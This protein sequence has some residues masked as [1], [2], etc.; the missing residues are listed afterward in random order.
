MNCVYNGLISY[1]SQPASASAS[2]IKGD[3][4]LQ[5][6]VDKLDYLVEQIALKFNLHYN[7]HPRKAF[8]L[9]TIL[10]Y[11]CPGCIVKALNQH[12]IR[13][14]D[15]FYTENHRLAVNML[16]DHLK[17]RLSSEGLDATVRSEVPGN[18]AI[19]DIL[20][21]PKGTNMQLVIEVKCG[22]GFDYSQI[23][24]YFLQDQRVA[25]VAIWRV[26]FR[27]LI[28][29]DRVRISEALVLATEAAINKAKIILEGRLNTC[30][31]VLREKRSKVVNP[32][33]LVDSILK[34]I[35]DVKNIVNA[36]IRSLK[37]AYS[38]SYD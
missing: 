34:G 20:V 23:F 7:G 25:L 17:A 29:L 5:Y 1:G 35:G 12:T 22:K 30:N 27:Q 28:V 21:E 2:A 6:L 10:K 16:I 15:I 38:M 33:E 11:R 3:V 13:N 36:L 18:Y 37:V 24:R 31:H 26:S 8:I 19:M 14:I 9:D 32:Q 4:H